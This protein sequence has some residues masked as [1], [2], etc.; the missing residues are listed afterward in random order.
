MSFHWT[1]GQGIRT[2][3]RWPEEASLGVPANWKMGTETTNSLVSALTR[4]SQAARLE[5]GF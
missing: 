2:D 3:T 1:R 5:Y 4:E